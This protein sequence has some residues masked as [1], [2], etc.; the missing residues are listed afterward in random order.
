MEAITWAVAR[1]NPTT[2]RTGITVHA[3]STW[4]L[5]YICGGSL[6]SSSCLS[7]NFTTEYASKLN[8]TM[9]MAATVVRTNT[10]SPKI[11]CAGVEDGAKILVGL[12]ECPVGSASTDQGAQAT[13]VPLSHFMCE[14]VMRS[15]L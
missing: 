10:D 6:R 5:P 7:L 15:N 2:M 14:P 3:S 9:N 1:N 11:D 4:L 8:T 12:A 13:S